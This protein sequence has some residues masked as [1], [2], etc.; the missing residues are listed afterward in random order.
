MMKFEKFLDGLRITPD[1]PGAETAT[2]RGAVVGK[3]RTK[4]FGKQRLL[5]GACIL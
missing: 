4:A 1:T 3:D 2:N 5:K